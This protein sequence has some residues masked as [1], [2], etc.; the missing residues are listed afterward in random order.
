MNYNL[1]SWKNVI[2]KIGRKTTHMRG[3]SK[4]IGYN[5][6]IGLIYSN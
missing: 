6:I 5:K 1:M 2:V 3:L 4:Y